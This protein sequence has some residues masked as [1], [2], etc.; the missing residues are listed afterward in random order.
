MNLPND[1]YLGQT[2]L[3]QLGSN[4]LDESA[5]VQAYLIGPL[6]VKCYD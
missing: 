1:S 6:W 2:Y 5:V 4:L 3:I